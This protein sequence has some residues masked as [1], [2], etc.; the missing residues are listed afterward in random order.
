MAPVPITAI[1]G[2]AVGG[3]VG[4]AMLAT[5]C[6]GTYL[7]RTQ[8]MK[9][10]VEAPSQVVPVPMPGASYAPA[11][12]PVTRTGWVRQQQPRAKSQRILR[13]PAR[14]ASESALPALLELGESEFG[15]GPEGREERPGAGEPNGTG[16]D[17]ELES[18]ALSEATAAS[19]SASAG[20]EDEW[21]AE[22]EIVNGS[23]IRTSGTHGSEGTE[24]IPIL[25][26]PEIPAP[27]GCPAP[28][29]PVEDFVLA[30][31]RQS[32]GSASSDSGDLTPGTPETLASCRPECVELELR[33][34]RS[35]GAF[36]RGRY[37]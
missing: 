2:G 8:D 7:H 32:V 12:A 3:V 13:S 36:V 21:E 15:D 19:S 34:H 4:L 35:L 9:V 17:A 28:T 1:I 20:E 26:P 37:V 10:D 23:R 30:F 14:R 25:G 31:E 5:L 29:T 18:T 33:R 22:G 16:T 11:P 24:L 6:T 27:G